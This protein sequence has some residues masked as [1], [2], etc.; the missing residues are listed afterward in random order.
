M[1]L[2]VKKILKKLLIITIGA[3]LFAAALEAFLVPNNV[4]DGG[5]VG[6]SL[7]VSHLS[8]INFGILLIVL[9]LPFLIMGYKHLGKSFVL[10][11]GYAIVVGSIATQLMHHIHPVTSD[12]LLGALFGGIVL[13]VG[14][15]MVI[16]TGG[17]LDGTEIVAI[18]LNKKSPFSV[19]E[20][21][22]F[23]NVFILGAAGFVFSW[24]S[25]MYSMLAY[26]VAFKVIDLTISGLEE[27]RSS[28]II[29]SKHEEIGEAIFHRLGRTVTY[30]E[31]IGGHSKEKKI[32]V[33]CI[34]SRL[35]ESKMKTIIQEIDPHALVVI[36][37]VSEVIGEGFK[38]NN[39]H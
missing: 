12:P 8:G 21:V 4:I 13:G 38:K 3:I 28:T 7:L 2:K 20:T 15:G 18:M 19:G 34:F 36:E 16:R 31:G 30:Y 17:S 33:Y 1:Q 6:I 39:I 27:M 14:V 29:T 35:E 26:F 11:T 22:M 32:S 10:Y 5:I 25:A 23:F 37:H 9:N 24:E